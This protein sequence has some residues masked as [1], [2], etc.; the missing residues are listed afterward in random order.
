[1]MTRRLRFL[2]LVVVLGFIVAHSPQLALADTLVSYTYTNGGY[3]FTA[4]TPYVGKH[5]SMTFD[6]SA[7][8]PASPLEFTPVGFEPL[9]TAVTPL[10]WSI[11]D[12]VNEYSSTTCQTLS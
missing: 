7:P 1:M 6:F 10:Y 2:A 8:L 9:E 12:G 5:L 3:S 11:D 4:G